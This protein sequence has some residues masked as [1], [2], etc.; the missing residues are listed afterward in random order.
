MPS[1]EGTLVAA[2]LDAFAAGTSEAALLTNTAWLSPYVAVV[3]GVL[4]LLDIEWG[5]GDHRSTTRRRGTRVATH[6]QGVATHC[7]T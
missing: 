7:Q 1:P 3:A 5:F 2:A 6:C 4:L